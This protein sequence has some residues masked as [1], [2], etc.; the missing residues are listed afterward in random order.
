MYLAPTSYIKAKLAAIPGLAV[1]LLVGV[2]PL[3]I[4]L[5][6]FQLLD[7]L[8]GIMA[9]LAA[10]HRI[11][12]ALAAVGMR[13]KTMMWV[14]V[15]MAHLF[16]DL[17]P[18]PLP[19]ELAATVAGLWIAVEAISICENGAR[20]GVPPPPPIRWAIE[21]FRGFYETKMID[22]KGE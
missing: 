2:H 14:Y 4:G 13:K 22:K 16:S 10:N 18:H 6:L 8:T 3:L 9:S 19:F 21:K 5:A 17:S 1:G 12:S 7:I 15:A 20:M 11:S